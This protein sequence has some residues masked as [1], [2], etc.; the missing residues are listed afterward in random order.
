MVIVKNKFDT[1]LEISESHTLNDD[2][3]NFVI[4]CIEATAV[5]ILTKLRTKYRIPSESLEKVNGKEMK[6]SLIVS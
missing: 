3:E 1:L 4:A 2:Y 6:R 5:F